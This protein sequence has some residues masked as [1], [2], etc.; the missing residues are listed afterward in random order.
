VRFGTGEPARLYRLE[1]A[2]DGARLA[3]LREAQVSAVAAK[4]TGVVVVTGN[5]RPSIACRTGPTTSGSSWR[6]R[7]TRSARGL[8]FSSSSRS[9]GLCDSSSE[10]FLVELPSDADSACALRAVDGA[11]DA[12]EWPLDRAGPAPDAAP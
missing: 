10:S 1:A 2:D 8:A 3:T 9:T 5:P 4:G 6:R 12:V 7:P 11:G